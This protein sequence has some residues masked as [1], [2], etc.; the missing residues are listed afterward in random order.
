M[1]RFEEMRVF[2]RVAER[3]S[4]TR[5]SDDLQ[6]PRATVTNLIKRLE[7]RLG[8][9]LLERTTRTVRLTPDGQAYY[10]R[11]VRLIAD[12][13]EAEGSFSNLAP[14]GLLRVNLQG[15]LARHF[16]VPTLPAFLARYPDIELTIGEDDRLVD[17]VREGIDCVLR[18]GTLQDSSMV[19]RRVAQLQQVT[20]ASPAYLEK[21]GEPADPSALESHRA[22]N[23]VSSATGKPVPLEFDIEGRITPVLLPGAV[24]VTG[25]ELYTGSAVAGLGM[26][27]VPRY[28][29]SDELA[30]GRLKII[31]AN[32]P[33]PPMP[34]SVLYPQ[35][36]QLSSRV[37]VFATWLRDIFEA[38]G[39]A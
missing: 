4:F 16:V 9:R 39:T 24:S 35:N 19:G 20:V 21:Y 22:V 1:D 13:E 38:A 30:S 23:Y 15:T 14:K 8:A 6:I 25:V 7:E 17:L 27:Q 2:V 18:A 26:V 37:R 5:A 33:P 34:V 32:F 31:L 36:R 29:V 28:R 10:G 12:M 3:Q 11:C